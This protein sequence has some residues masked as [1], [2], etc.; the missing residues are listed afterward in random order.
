MWR[1]LHFFVIHFIIL[2][3]Y[4]TWY[5]SY[6]SFVFI[7]LCL[8]RSDN[9]SHPHVTGPIY[10]LFIVFF[11]FPLSLFPSLLM[12]SEALGPSSNCPWFGTHN[13]FPASKHEYIL[14]KDV[15]LKHHWWYTGLS[16]FQVCCNDGVYAD[17]MHR[18]P[19]CQ[20]K[21]YFNNET[22]CENFQ[23]QTWE[24]NFYV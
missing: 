17:S 14:K 11:V 8:W 22:E 23:K 20:I 2:S 24:G 9:K 15:I 6:L 12:R 3:F 19:R 13:P 16:R 7:L 5:I 4:P 1:F 10:T 21:K 18:K